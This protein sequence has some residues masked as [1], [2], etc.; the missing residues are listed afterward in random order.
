MTHRNTANENIER[1]F[2]EL[3]LPE[4]LIHYF[5]SD[6]YIDLFVSVLLPADYLSNWGIGC[7][8][9][10]DFILHGIGADNVFLQATSQHWELALLYYLIIAAFSSY[11]LYTQYQQKKTAYKEQCDSYRRIHQ[12]LAHD[13]S[14]KNR[15]FE[16]E[17][18]DQIARLNNIINELNQSLILTLNED[19][20][21]KRKYSRIEIYHTPDSSPILSNLK[22]RYHIVQKPEEQSE[23]I[24]KPGLL[25][26]LMTKVIFPIYTTLCLST[27]AYWI[28]YIGS[29]V[30]VG[31]FA[32]IG[33]AG[34]AT[35]IGFSLPLAFALPYSILKIRNWFRH[36]GHQSDEHARLAKIAENDT[37]DLLQ[38]ALRRIE[39]N[40]EVKQLN[41][42]CKRLQLQPIP[43]PLV[44]PVANN[45]SLGANPTVKAVT[46]LYSTI[47]NEYT[48]TQYTSWFVSDFFKSV[49]T[50]AFSIPY[51]G[52]IVGSIL[53]ATSVSIGFIEMVRRYREAK[54]ELVT[55]S[56]IRPESLMTLYNERVATL[57][58][59]KIEYADT[60]KETNLHIID[61]EKKLINS[62]AILNRPIPKPPQS[63]RL[64]QTI[65]NF[66]DWQTTG[67]FFARIFC[68]AGAAIVI[69]FT[70][71]A[72][73]NPITLGILIS[74]ACIFIAIKIYQA[75]QKKKESDAKELVEKIKDMDEQIYITKLTQQNLIKRKSI[76]QLEITGSQTILSDPVCSPK[77]PGHNV[78]SLFQTQPSIIK[79]E[80]LAE[81]TV[82][83]KSS[84]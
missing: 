59:F 22:I 38:N 43:Q 19:P 40:H 54:A 58:A 28:F 68:S 79:L 17:K 66:L 80:S 30:A 47:V 57:T 25:S 64:M 49:P 33:I 67:I 71:V 60:I 55:D 20:Q 23:R 29:T 61:S 52:T 35:W 70:A 1:G 44:I 15:L 8:N 50:L 73:S 9:L 45:D 31:N 77:N 36:K 21:A 56:P 7:T 41:D 81:K 39:F 3:P 53:I 16:D 10:S 83:S 75:S 4:Q 42:E 63:M 62:S 27:F 32:D 37:P 6:D 18:A 24:K 65:Y 51:F 76:L 78:L 69:P 82:L 46:T 34:V 72:L 2:V 74:S 5:S 48:L 12:K 26:K 84:P 14:L 13:L 11:S